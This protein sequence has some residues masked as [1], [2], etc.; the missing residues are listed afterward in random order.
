VKAGQTAVSSAAARDTTTQRWQRALRGDLDAIVMMALRKEAA[1][2][3]GSAE[4]LAQDIARYLE[5]LPVLAQ[6]GSR[7]YR[8]A[9]YLRRHR[10]QAVAA[11]F[12]LASL[13]TGA[14]L[15]LWQ[16]QVARTARDRAQAALAETEQALAQANQITTFLTS[17]FE[18]SE[19]TRSAGGEITARELLRRGIR[20]V[21]QLGDQPL[22]QAA[23]FAVLGRVQ[24]SL[25]D[26]AEARRL[27]ERALAIYIQQ[28][29]EEHRDVA[30]TLLQLAGMQ[31]NQGLFPEAEASAR[32]AR[33][34]YERARAA[35]PDSL[36]EALMM[37]SG[38]A[39]YRGDL[40]DADSIAQRAVQASTGIPASKRSQVR[41]LIHQGSV[42]R[43][44]GE[45][46]A[47]EASFRAALALARESFGPDHPFAIDALM[48]LGYLMGD[49]PGRRAEAESI[50]R[51][52]IDTRR[53]T[54]GPDHYLL[55]HVLNDL[56]R[57][58][59]RQ[60]RDQ[61]ALPYFRQGYAILERALG[62]DH[63]GTADGKGTLGGA[64]DRAGLFEE[65][66]GMYRD[67]VSLA[68]RT[69]GPDHT[70]TAGALSGL[71]MTLAH[72]G[73]LEEAER[74]M[75]RAIAVRLE[76]GGPNT[77]LMAVMNG[78]LAEILMLRR[79]YPQAELLLQQSAIIFDSHSIPSTH[80]DYRQLLERFVNLYEAWGRPEQA[81]QYRRERE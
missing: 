70:N 39:V 40:N 81:E 23:M 15:T 80:A 7:R 74:T 64:L 19:P 69:Y 72:A 2:R 75:R 77:P 51:S 5:G 45:D 50:F 3:Y 18:A 6:R 25:G 59:Q 67:A 65:A 36:V 14:G 43:R 20:Q 37:V 60:G 55:A 11:L 58:I 35:Q 63:P 49:E 41:A 52:V 1:R 62:P 76:L 8:I 21:E 54:L 4:L 27:Y 16:A 79:A 46:A 22:V 12:V 73:K 47:A 34:I 57:L 17:M 78:S 24:G 13:L 48:P 31:R 53:R 66:E 38:L 68:E 33:A 10:V 9:K 29:G 56:G 44:T 42:Q 30:G 71:A 28:H 32:R 61:E 26:F